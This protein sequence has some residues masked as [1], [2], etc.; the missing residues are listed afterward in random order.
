MMSPMTMQGLRDEN[1]SRKTIC[2]SDRNNARHSFS[3]PLTAKCM[4]VLLLGLRGRRRTDAMNLP[5]QTLRQDEG[6]FPKGLQTDSQKGVTLIEVGLVLAIIVTV[7]VASVVT[8]GVILEQRRVSQ[9]IVDI[10][11]I[12]TAITKWTDGGLIYYGASLTVEG[13]TPGTTE[14]LTPDPRNL[15]KWSQISALL[16]L[17]MQTLAEN[18]GTLV[19][20]NA[21]PWGESYEIKPPVPPPP[22]AQAPPATQWTLV[23]HKVPLTESQILASQ[24]INGN[25]GGTVSRQDVSNTEANVQ[26][27]YDINLP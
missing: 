15:G 17:P 6:V 16:P 13:A 3:E 10:V 11:S 5:N 27:V 25:V 4:F 2:S 23:V 21:N 18:E 8:L 22:P 19:L 24:L 9:A 26:V 12:Q 14:T 7:I 1:G 20:A